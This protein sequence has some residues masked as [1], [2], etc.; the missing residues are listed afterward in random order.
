[1][2]PVFPKEQWELELARKYTRIWMAVVKRRKEE[3]AAMDPLHTTVWTQSRALKRVISL[4]YEKAQLGGYNKT[5]DEF[6]RLIRGMKFYKEAKTKQKFSSTSLSSTSK[7]Q[8]K[9]KDFDDD[10]L[11]SD[12]TEETETEMESSMGGYTADEEE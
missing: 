2:K 12:Y 11:P 9:G 6:N 1:M 7:V 4:I 10:Y 5:T 3:R 8:V